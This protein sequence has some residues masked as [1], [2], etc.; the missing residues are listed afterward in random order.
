MLRVDAI[1]A[2]YGHVG[3]LEQ[4]SLE[5]RQG[6]VVTLIGSNGA[7]K[8]TLLKTISGLLKPTSGSIEFDGRDITGIA[9][10]KA[11]GAGLAMV[12][13]GR[14]LFGPMTVRE[15][16]E[17]GAYALRRS[18]SYGSQ[19]EED[20]DVVHDLFPVLAERSEQP[21]ATLSGGE[22]Q[23]LAMARALMSRPRLLLL[24][25]PSLGLAPKV[26][27]EIFGVL[28]RLQSRGV[29]ILLVEQDASVALRHADRG[30][31][32]RTGRV[33][34]EGTAE[35]LLA[36]DDVRLIYLGAWKSAETENART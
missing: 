27:T 12:P 16:L 29:T 3:V 6:E 2:G 9:P 32:L 7:G 4:V 26:I 18:R 17:L 19:L 20:L 11:V 33:A 28:A 36:N 5:V 31:V 1:D 10:E 24:D 22:Q 15:N 35:E 30:Y 13:E 14:R 21:A 8:S 23:M 34:L 25:E